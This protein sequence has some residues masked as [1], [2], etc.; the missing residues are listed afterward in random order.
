MVDRAFK[1]FPLIIENMFQI[2]TKCNC[3]RFN[4]I[5][6]SKIFE[7]IEKGRLIAIRKLKKMLVF[8]KIV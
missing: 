4:T 6:F 2:L 7:T 1:S 3:K 8:K 5:Y